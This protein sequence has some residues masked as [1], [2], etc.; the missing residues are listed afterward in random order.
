MYKIIE[1][2]TGYVI[3]IAKINVE[4]RKELENAGFICKKVGA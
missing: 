1:K 4:T 2:T 3:D